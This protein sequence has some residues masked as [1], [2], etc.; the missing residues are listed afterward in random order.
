M[1]SPPEATSSAPSVPPSRSRRYARVCMLCGVALIAWSVLAPVSALL[2]NV[3]QNRGAGSTAH[4]A[5][6][7]STKTGVT[8][9]AQTLVPS[10]R[11]STP[12][13]RPRSAVNTR[14]QPPLA[15]QRVLKATPSAGAP[16]SLI[17][18]ADRRE[19]MHLYGIWKAAWQTRDVNGIL[20]L[21]SPQIQF[22]SVG[23]DKVTYR[24]LR[25]W[26]ERLWANGG[27]TIKD[28]GEPHLSINGDQA[29]LIAGQ[30]YRRYRRMRFTSRYFLTKEVVKN[31]SPVGPES[32]RRWRITE[33]DFLPFQGST[34]V[35][36]QIY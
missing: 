2:W 22:R 6:V 18:Q 16:L 7:A 28:I 25:S 15:R 19:I 21:Y 5:A 27:Y 11:A 3:L 36:T 23:T 10:A 17:E 12:P 32:I 9:P 8:T 26:F 13:H 1:N 30:S 14:P 29:I 34:D 35:Q 31:S 20:K 33:E 4:N 24:D